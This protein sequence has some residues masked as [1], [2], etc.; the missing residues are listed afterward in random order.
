MLKSTWGVGTNIAKLISVST[1]ISTGVSSVLIVTILGLGIGLTTCLLAS[2]GVGL[3]TCLLAAT[4]VG[5]FS[6]FIKLGWGYGLGILIISSSG[7][8]LSLLSTLTG[9]WT[10]LVSVITLVGR[11]V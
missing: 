10:C 7:I 11:T 2:T 3:I 8:T 9:V 4:G 5:P 6:L 1:D